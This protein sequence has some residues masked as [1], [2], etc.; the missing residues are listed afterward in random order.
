MSRGDTPESEGEDAVSEDVGKSKHDKD[1]YLS[2]FFY[3]QVARRTVLVSNL[4]HLV[5]LGAVSN[6]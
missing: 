6:T 4:H 3:I 2:L 5:T 1:E